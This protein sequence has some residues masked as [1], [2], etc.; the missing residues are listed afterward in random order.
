MVLKVINTEIC[1]ILQIVKD[2][3]QTVNVYIVIAVWFYRTSMIC[4]ITDYCVQNTA[5]ISN[6]K[7]NKMHLTYVICEKEHYAKNMVLLSFV[8]RQTSEHVYNIKHDID[9]V[10]HVNRHDS[11]L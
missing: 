1:G 3:F 8:S 9:V 4:P 6:N 10:K 2:N 11:L 5:Q 7:F